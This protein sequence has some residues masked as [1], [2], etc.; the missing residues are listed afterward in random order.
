MDI[1]FM[2]S[3]A[4][5]DALEYPNAILALLSTRWILSEYNASGPILLWSDLLKNF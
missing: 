3:M 5:V 4:R 1:D 2:L